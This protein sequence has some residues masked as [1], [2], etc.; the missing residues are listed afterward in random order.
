MKLQLHP[1]SMLAQREVDHS[2]MAD[3][4][5]CMRYLFWKHV[6]CLDVGSGVAAHFGVALHKGLKTRWAELNAPNR[7]EMAELAFKK[8]LKETD[9]LHTLEMG[10]LL[11][12]IYDFK[13]AERDKQLSLLMNEE[14]LKEEICTDYHSGGVFQ[15]VG[16]VDKVVQSDLLGLAII[17]HKSTGYF[18]ANYFQQ[19][20]LS[21]QAAIYAELTGVAG[22]LGA[23]LFKQS[24]QNLIVDCLKVQKC[25]PPDDPGGIPTNILQLLPIAVGTNRCT[26]TWDNLCE[27]SLPIP[28]ANDVSIHTHTIVTGIAN[29]IFR[30]VNDYHINSAFWRQDSYGERKARA[31]L[32]PPST[33]HCFYFGKCPFFELC[34]HPELEQNIIEQCFPVLKPWNPEENGD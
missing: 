23:V 26:T 24:P 33:R 22:P 15:L 13:Y 34:L 11:L 12:R 7:V 1:E 3:G 5:K 20:D 6:V 19:F 32:F 29:N 27:R 30:A 21:L 14:V 18:S 2:I 25:H 4:Q 17:D 8:A 28:L 9:E 10:L 16:R 31:Y